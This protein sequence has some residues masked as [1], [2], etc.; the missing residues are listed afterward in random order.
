MIRLAFLLSLFATTAHAV[1]LPER[2]DYIGPAVHALEEDGASPLYYIDE[3]EEDW[4]PVVFFGGSGT[5]VRVFAITEFLRSLRNDLKLRV[6]SVERN[7]FG[8][9]P[10]IE[11]HSYDDYA[12]E[13]KR[14]LD[15]LSIDRPI[16]VGIS[17]G[18]PYLAA[19]AAALGDRVASVHMLA[20]YSQYDEDNPDTSGLCGLPAAD[21]A[22]AAGYYAGDPVAW[23][24]LGENSPTARIPGFTSASRDDGAR[25]FSMGGQ[26]MD[27]AALLAE[28]KRFCTLK[29][30]DLSGVKA[31]AFIYY[32]E[33]DATVKPVHAAFWQNAYPNVAKVRA[34][35]GE[36]HDIQYRHWDQ[37]LVDMA[38]MH[39]QT[40][41]C[42][43][44]KSTLVPEGDAA[45][46]QSNGATVGI[47][48][49]AD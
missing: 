7:G 31:P 23:W 39:D 25:T 33:A 49:W 6:I 20:A 41:M 43:D 37:V 17:G 34:Y 22:G 5:S 2:F 9:T 32:G 16:L 45:T 18:G 3:G 11:G 47:C 21:M 36:G 19:T 48:A 29:V 24:T 42:V 30:A 40:V 12:A 26:K 38:G 44:G 35:E 13:V 15:H 28:F 4:T 1:D 27:G 10:L 8:R 46:A 14:V